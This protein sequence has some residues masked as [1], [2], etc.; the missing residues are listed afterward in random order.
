[1]ARCARVLAGFGLVLSL[2]A[3]AAGPVGAQAADGTVEVTARC[4]EQSGRPFVEGEIANESGGPI[5]VIRVRPLAHPG[6]VFPSGVSEWP[7]EDGDALTF[8]EPRLE[9]LQPGD[10]VL[11]VTS[12]GVLRVECDANRASRA[13][14]KS[15]R[16]RGLDDPESEEA[17]EAAAEM[18]GELESTFELDALYQLL[19]PDVRR[20]VS[21]EA[22]ACWYIDEYAPVTTPGEV[23]VTDI[24]FDEWTWGVNGETYDAATV[25]FEQEFE[26][27]SGGP[28]GPEVSLETGTQ[29][30]V[31]AAGAWRWFFGGSEEFLD[32]LRT[33][34]G[35]EWLV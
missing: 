27:G 19:H 1:M 24:E 22:M 29:H 16:V 11:V 18:L 21:F 9:P 35:V 23:T 34:C 15:L 14:T 5:Q 30:L 31:F 2:V 26:T 20:E 10:G 3:L 25:D 28:G 7:L 32:G 6:P 12:V 8:S 13:V 17:V 4:T 33:D